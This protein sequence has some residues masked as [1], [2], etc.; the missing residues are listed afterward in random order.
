M[1]DKKSYMNNESIL[2]EGFFSKLAKMLGLSSTDKKRLKK[3]KKVTNALK[4]Y[5]KS[6]KNLEKK[7]QQQTGNKNF[8]LPYAK[9]KLTDFL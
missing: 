5:N 2:A 7:V 1:S 9:F 3:N 8:K 6:W 4:D